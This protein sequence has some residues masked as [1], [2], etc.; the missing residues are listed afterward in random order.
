MVDVGTPCY[1]LTNVGFLL[2][3][4]LQI[5]GTV[6]LFWYIYAVWDFW[7]I[8]GLW[9]NWSDPTRRCQVEVKGESRP[10]P[11]FLSAYWQ[12]L[13]IT[14]PWQINLI[15]AILSNS[16]FLLYQELSYDES[17]SSQP[18]AWLVKKYLFYA[19]NHKISKRTSYWNSK[20][21]PVHVLFLW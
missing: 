9:A 2:L 15:Q 1:C 17:L 5:F 14:K 10:K 3:W 4:F 13:T 19:C 11:K 12:W 21:F 20:L 8:L 16:Y 6:C 7:L 18:E